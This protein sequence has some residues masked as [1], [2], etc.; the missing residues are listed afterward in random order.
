MTARFRFGRRAALALILVAA[1]SPALAQSEPVTD[2]AALA[3]RGYAVGDMTLGSPD[4]PLAIVE[5]SSLTCPHCAAFHRD[6]LPA[7]KEKYIDTGL[8]RLTLREVYFDQFGLWASMIARCAG[9][10]GFFE[11]IE[12]LFGKQDEWLRAEDPVEEL[13]RVGRL[14]GLPADR[15]QACLQDEG[16]MLRLVEDFQTATARDAVRSTPTFLIGG[17]TVSGNR[18]VAEFSALIDKQLPPAQN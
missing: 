10:E 6:T 3:L 14:G 2:P 4:A 12:T 13:M 5:Y 15:M 8:V 18:S 17:E 1:A 16:L 11:Q 9:P 7:I